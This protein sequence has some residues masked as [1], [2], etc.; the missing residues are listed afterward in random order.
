MKRR[1]K[2]TL[3]SHPTG[4]EDIKFDDL[5]DGDNGTWDM[6]SNDPRVRHIKGLRRGTHNDS[7]SIHLKHFNKNPR[8]RGFPH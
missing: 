8:G 5:D 6:G 2:K 1:M 3:I 4:L 7:A